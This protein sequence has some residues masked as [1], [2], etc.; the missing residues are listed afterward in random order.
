[1]KNCDTHIVCSSNKNLGLCISK[2]DQ[3]VHHCFNNHLNNTDNY[4][5]L[6]ETTAIDTLETISDKINIFLNKNSN[7]L[8]K[9][10]IEFISHF[11]E[12][13]NTEKAFPH[14][15]LLFKV[16]KNKLG[17]RS[18]ISLY[19]TI[20][21]GLSVW[22]DKKLQPF[23]KRLW[24][25]TKSSKEFLKKLLQYMS[26]GRRVLLFIAD[27]IGIYNNIDTTHAL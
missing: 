9:Q 22:L 21:Y 27:S 18:I 12:Y 19:G 17:T 15:Y 24:K 2:R 8:T 16:H 4:Q 23:I 26:Y 6:D 1:M 14:F 11:N 7:K 25:Y 3:Y 13:K 5:K 20:L 10:E